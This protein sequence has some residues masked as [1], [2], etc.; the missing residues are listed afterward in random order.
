MSEIN[1]KN[2]Y[3][4]HLKKNVKQSK[5]IKDGSLKN[6]GIF[7]TL[8]NKLSLVNSIKLYDYL[9]NYSHKMN[10]LYKVC[11]E[12]NNPCNKNCLEINPNFCKNLMLV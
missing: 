10:N 5:Q 9:N 6:I 7:N 4:N 11:F 8:T 2:K 12:N 3:F 1:T